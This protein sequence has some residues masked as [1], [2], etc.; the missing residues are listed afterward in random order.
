M[1]SQRTMLTL[2]G[3]GLVAAMFLVA[4]CRG[5]ERKPEETPAEKSQ[6]Q[7]IATV[8]VAA[9]ESRSATPGPSFH[10]MDH[11]A[12]EQFMKDVVMPKMRAAFTA[13]EPDEFREM[14]CGACHGAGAKDKTFKMPNPKLPRLPTDEAGWAALAAEEPEALKFMK[15]VVVPE[16]ARLLGEA[17][18]DPVTRKGFG[19]FECHTA[20]K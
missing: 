12:R 1:P 16:M 13:W 19:C 6:D 10:D 15:E 7:P 20:K 14:K 18:Y 3:L 4:A 11:E 17:P 2:P 8:P 9:E 5:S